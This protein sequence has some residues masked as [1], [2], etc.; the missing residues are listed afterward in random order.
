MWQG[1][2]RGLKIGPNLDRIQIIKGW[3]G[4]Q[5][6]L[7]EKVYDV[8]W[9]GD[10]RPGAVV[11]LPPVGNTVD[12]ANA[13]RSRSIGGIGKAPSLLFTGRMQ[14][15]GR[16]E[17]TNMYHVRTIISS[18]STVARPTSV[19][20][21]MCPR[22]HSNENAGSNVAVGGRTDARDVRSAGPAP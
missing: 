20:P 1:L 17:E 4:K 7:H 22:S 6:G 21:M 16:P 14:T 13:T 11:K 8:V 10:R 15:H 2:S 9:S 3:L 5:G 12:V 19:L 18:A